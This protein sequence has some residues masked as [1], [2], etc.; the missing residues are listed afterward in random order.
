MAV[1]VQRLDTQRDLATGGGIHGRGGGGG[2]TGTGD[3]KS[4]EEEASGHRSDPVVEC[5]AHGHGVLATP[6]P[7]RLHLPLRL[8]YCSEGRRAVGDSVYMDIA[9]PLPPGSGAPPSSDV[10]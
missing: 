8:A 10:P 4:K 6:P 2:G 5:A 9:A 7:D 1:E 3:G